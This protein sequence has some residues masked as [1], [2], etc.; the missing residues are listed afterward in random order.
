M[1]T[2]TAHSHFLTYSPTSLEAFFLWVAHP[3]H[4]SRIFC[5]KQSSMTI[6]LI[7]DISL[8]C[9]M[10]AVFPSS[11]CFSASKSWLVHYDHLTAVSLLRF[12]FSIPWQ[13][14][15][16][17]IIYLLLNIH[18]SDNISC[19]CDSCI[20]A[21][22][23]QYLSEQLNPLSPCFIRRNVYRQTMSDVQ[24]KWLS[25]FICSV[26]LWLPRFYKM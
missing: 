24:Q 5:W 11:S 8:I 23:K 2:A 7:G 21:Q 13:W 26:T 19:L 14:N 15:T 9:Q 1:L 18:L 16:S 6:I 10:L 17:L 4:L 22:R 12:T 25:V 20:T 3:S